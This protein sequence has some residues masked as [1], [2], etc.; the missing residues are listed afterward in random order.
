LKDADLE[1]KGLGSAVKETKESTKTKDGPAKRTNE[2]IHEVITL[3]SGTDDSDE[4][5]SASEHEQERES[6]SKR[7]KTNSR[8][9]LT[10]QQQR[11]QENREKV[12]QLLLEPAEED[13]DDHQPQPQHQQHQQQQQHQPQPQHQ[14]QHQHHQQ[15][16]QIQHGG[17]AEMGDKP[18]EYVA[19]FEFSSQE[20]EIDP[21]ATE[22]NPL[23]L[24][25][26]RQTTPATTTPT[27]TTT[28]T[29]HIVQLP[30]QY[31]S[32]NAS[33]ASNLSPPVQLQDHDP[34][35]ELV[36]LAPSPDVD[37]VSPNV[38]PVSPKREP[39][40]HVDRYPSSPQA[41]LPID[42]DGFDSSQEEEVNPFDMSD[43][44]DEDQVQE[45]KEEKEKEHQQH[46]HHH[47][48]QQ[49]E[50]DGATVSNASVSRNTSGYSAYS[51]SR[52]GSDDESP[53][54]IYDDAVQSKKLAS[55]HAAGDVVRCGVMWCDVM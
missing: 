5:V 24:Q 36:S 29:P 30:D 12:V 47:K 16:H 44:E 19:P 26:L 22:S 35:D 9:E 23:E 45:E 4:Y 54:A 33:F 7:R 39:P 13:E 3:G 52:T 46:H 27:P 2:V 43:E 25:A 10:K 11:D 53:F 49:D 14:H 32:D 48:H 42:V 34:F 51:G 38:D 41:E 21:F 18:N 50:Y 20:E 6:I 28:T 31:D 8:P 55:T 40:I 1:S 17:D 15:Q 37:R